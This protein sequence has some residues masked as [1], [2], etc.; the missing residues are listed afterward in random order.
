[1]ASG[2]VERGVKLLRQAED[3]ARSM[4]FEFGRALALAQLAEALLTAGEILEPRDK[5]TDAIKIARD[6]GER[7]N[8]GWAT[9]MLGEVAYKSGQRE[10]AEAR[11]RQALEIA[12]ALEMAPLQARCIDGLRRCT[13]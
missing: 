9:C 5:A 2:Q 1:M 10:D 8:E 4:S 13:N 7:G 3:Q 6:A 11:Y 12:E